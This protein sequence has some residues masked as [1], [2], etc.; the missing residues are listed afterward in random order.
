MTAEGP[1]YAGLGAAALRARRDLALARLST[2]ELCPRACRVD[3][4]RGGRGD[5]R[6][7][8]WAGVSAA[9]AHHGEER[10][11][12]GSRGS[13]TVF[14]CGCSLRCVFCQNWETSRAEEGS[15]ADAEELAAMM[16]RL[17]AE[18]CHNINLVTASHVVPQILEALVIA[19]GGG[20]RLPL[21]YNTG[22]YD[23]LETLRLLDGIV[24]IYLP[25][26]KLWGPELSHRYF[27]APDYARR[28]REAVREMYRQVGVLRV[29][30][31][32]GTARRG[33]VGGPPGLPRLGQESRRIFRWI[34]RELSA[35]TRVNV[36]RQY[37][38][39]GDALSP[40]LYPELSAPLSAP[41]YEQA[42]RAA[43]EAGLTP[44]DA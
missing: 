36:M 27:A 15:G 18:G 33:V 11:L 16:L 22:G 44:L 37:H 19:A 40:G 41:E 31:E 25:D 32:T 8:R 7:G 30:P 43:R 17:Q 39:A 24:D 35:E 6:S 42:L 38:A 12:S 1:A 28:A 34:A 2:C 29:D 26:F 23:S 13:G 10:V 5:C 21:V 3:R 9:F 14:F 20:L 4:L